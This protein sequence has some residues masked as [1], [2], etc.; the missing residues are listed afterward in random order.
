MF[1]ATAQCYSQ[2]R[3]LPPIPELASDFVSLHSQCGA[4]LE[5]GPKPGGGWGSEAML[6]ALE[7]GG[8]TEAIPQ[9]ANS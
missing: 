5:D 6:P 8:K 1:R 9:C 4:P 3:P 2:V 7:N